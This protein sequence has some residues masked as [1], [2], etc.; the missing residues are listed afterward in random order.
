MHLKNCAIYSSVLED[1]FLYNL[2]FKKKNHQLLHVCHTYCTA[3]YERHSGK[4]IQQL[5]KVK[6]FEYLQ[7]SN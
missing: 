1:N 7:H 2:F 6:G 3:L 4:Y 5:M